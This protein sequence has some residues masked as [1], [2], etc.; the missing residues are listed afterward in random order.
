MAS[1]A[2]HPNRAAL[3]RASSLSSLARAPLLGLLLCVVVSFAAAA[4]PEPETHTPHLADDWIEPYNGLYN[5]AFTGTPSPFNPD[6]IANYVW[7]PS[8]DTSQLQVVFLPP[9]G[10]TLINGTD[11]ASFQGYAS[12]TNNVSS[13]TVSGPGVV[14]FYWN[15]EVPAWLEF[16]S[17]DLLPSAAAGVTLSISEYNQVEIV[18]AFPSVLFGCVSSE[19]ARYV[20]QC[21]ACASRL[22]CHTRAC[23]SCGIM[24]MRRASA[25]ESGLHQPCPYGVPSQRLLHVSPGDEPAA[26]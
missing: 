10:V 5:G 17:P 7:S 4:L 13:V 12:L 19:C 26:V 15:T 23:M 14:Q 20:H 11:P 8:V 2:E 21:C 3:G 25:D 6:P 1:R 24:S 9:N 18:R 16:D 22:G